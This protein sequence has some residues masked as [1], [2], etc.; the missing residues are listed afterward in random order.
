MMKL[1]VSTTV[2]A[3]VAAGAIFITKGRSAHEA[4]SQV[5]P[6]QMMANPQP[7]SDQRLI[8]RSVVFDPASETENHR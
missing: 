4:T 6:L 1:L 7:L 8:D 5:N 3:I 2:A